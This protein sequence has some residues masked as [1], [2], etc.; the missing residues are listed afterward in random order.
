MKYLSKK[1]T[2]NERALKKNEVYKFI[3]QQKF[4]QIKFWLGII[5]KYITKSVILGHCMQ[6]KSVLCFVIR[7]CKFSA[8]Y[9]KCNCIS[10]QKFQTRFFKF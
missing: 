3:C 6:I 5:L 8:D 10:K 9:V 4:E 1:K 7:L 2:W